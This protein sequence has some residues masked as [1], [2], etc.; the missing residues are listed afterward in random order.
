[1]V[2]ARNELTDQPVWVAANALYRKEDIQCNHEQKT[3]ILYVGRL[4]PAKNVDIIL[5]AFQLSQLSD[6]GY[7]LEIVGFGSLAETLNT[8]AVALKIDQNFIYHGRIDDVEKLKHIYARTLFSIS[9]GYIGLSLTQSLGFGTPML[10]AQ[11]AAHSPEIELAR[12]GGVKAFRPT[13][14]EGLADGMRVL[15]NEL[16]S[17]GLDR[18]HLSAEVSKYYSAQAMAKGIWE[19]LQDK[20][21]RLGATGWPID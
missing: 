3:T 4:E 10:Y 19:A 18:V 11:D 2:P 9:P 1:V 6:Q 14:A 8:Q 16:E 13:T 12:F 7:T 5:K 20:P 17:T 15:H 21:S